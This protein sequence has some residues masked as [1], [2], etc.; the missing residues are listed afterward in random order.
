MTGVET[1][2]PLKQSRTQ[3]C[4]HTHR[5][6]PAQRSARPL[7]LI[8]GSERASSRAFAEARQHPL[9]VLQRNPF[10]E[11]QA[12]IRRVHGH[13]VSQCML[14]AYQATLACPALPATFGSSAWSFC[15]RTCIAG[16][17]RRTSNCGIKFG[18]T[19]LRAG[20]Y[21]GLQVTVSG[22]LYSRGC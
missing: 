2:N 10:E 1:L 13:P 22:Y 14:P 21:C 11:A 5:F 20:R 18:F 12:T 4:L 17:G 16:Q 3:D 15:E 19:T 7:T 9:W 8:C 6:T